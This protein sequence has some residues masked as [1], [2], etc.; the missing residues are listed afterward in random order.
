MEQSNLRKDLIIPRY[1]EKISPKIIE[2][3]ISYK[4]NLLSVFPIITTINNNNT[5]IKPF[6][7]SE[8]DRDRYLLSFA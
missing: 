7:L 6:D 4:N 2:P 1:I 3:I 5:G 8:T